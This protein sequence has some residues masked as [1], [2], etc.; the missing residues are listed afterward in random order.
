LCGTEATFA[1]ALAEINVLDVTFV[2]S[3]ATHLVENQIDVFAPELATTRIFE[4][5]LR[6]ILE[7][8]TSTNHD[9]NAESPV[10]NVNFIDYGGLWAL[11]HVAT[12]VIG[13]YKWL[14]V[15]PEGET[16]RAQTMSTASASQSPCSESG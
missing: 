14:L 9:G 15:T 7:K 16:R 11:E 5:L 13:S 1:H 10:H 12:Y 2:S 3:F 4:G 8:A 6:H